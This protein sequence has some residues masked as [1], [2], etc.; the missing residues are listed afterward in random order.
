MD[1]LT[2]NDINRAE[3]HTTRFRE[4]YDIDEVD[5]LLDRA[6]HTIKVLGELVMRHADL[7]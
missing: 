1:L 6:A 7:Q 2:P 4:G 5:D 3:F